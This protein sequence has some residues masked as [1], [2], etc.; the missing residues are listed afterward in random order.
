M[1]KTLRVA[2]VAIAKNEGPFIE[3]WIAYHRLLGVDHFFIYDNSVRSSST[4]HLHKY[5]EFISCRRIISYPFERKPVQF[6][7]Y[8]DSLVR[9]AEQFDWVAYIDIDEFIVLREHASIQEFLAQYVQFDCIQ[10][11]WLTFGH[12]G[13]YSDDNRLIT[14]SCILRNSQHDQCVKTIVRPNAIAN[15]DVRAHFCTLKPKKVAVNVARES[16][17]PAIMQAVSGPNPLAACIH[18]YKFRSYKNFISKYNRGTANFRWDFS[19]R[20]SWRASKEGYLRHFIEACCL[21]CNS[22][23]DNY[24]IRFSDKIQRFIAS[25]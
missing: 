10:L 4:R 13:K 5:K 15:K 21:H 3:E 23:Y 1:N 7:A 19:K 2:I 16:I 11:N 9:G 25:H 17:H 8:S 12:S 18:H 22:T 14:E 6:R 24:M 20:T